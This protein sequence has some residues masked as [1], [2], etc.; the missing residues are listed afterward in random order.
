M[1]CRIFK[2]SKYAGGLLSQQKKGLG[3]MAEKIRR[4]INVLKLS[5]FHYYLLDQK[6]FLLFSEKIWQTPDAS[7]SLIMHGKFWS[8]Y[9]PLWRKY[10]TT[11]NPCVWGMSTLWRN[12]AWSTEWEI[13]TKKYL[14]STMN[15]SETGVRGA[16]KDKWKNDTTHGIRDFREIRRSS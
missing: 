11:S 14:V 3:I 10:K 16:N 13:E 15:F 9:L 1:R 7:L 12:Q 2:N 8:Y 4:T 6:Q 5:I